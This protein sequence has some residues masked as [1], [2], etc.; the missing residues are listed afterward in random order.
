MFEYFIPLL[1]LV[2]TIYVIGIVISAYWLWTHLR[3]DNNRLIITVAGSLTWP[4]MITILWII[5]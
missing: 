1:A 4:A 2:V 3:I 5:S